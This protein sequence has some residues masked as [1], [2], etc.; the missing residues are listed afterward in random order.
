MCGYTDTDEMCENSLSQ[1]VVSDNDSDD[2]DMLPM[3]RSEDGHSGI[4][5]DMY[6][7]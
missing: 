7:Y 6:F 3:R 4:N 5:G 1:N 2:G